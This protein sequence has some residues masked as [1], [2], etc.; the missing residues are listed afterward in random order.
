MTDLQRA[1]I[2][3]AA[4]VEDLNRA[5]DLGLSAG[6]DV[7]HTNDEDEMTAA[8]AAVSL[9]SPEVYAEYVKFRRELG[10]V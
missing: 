8:K 7:N 10:Y 9:I 6:N 5:D 2:K 1:E 3:R 4:R